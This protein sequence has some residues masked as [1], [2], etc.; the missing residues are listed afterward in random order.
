[1]AFY[2][3]KAFGAEEHAVTYF[4]EVVDIREVRRW[5]LFPDEPNDRK[6]NKRYYQIFVRSV[7]RLLRPIY[8]RRYR[9]IVFI[10]TTWNKF[11]RAVEINDLYD[12]SSLE[13]RL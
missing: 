13:E 5:Q 9:R 11:V 3:T 6:G 2:Q 10:P 7:Q 12:E 1:M 4:A 8:S